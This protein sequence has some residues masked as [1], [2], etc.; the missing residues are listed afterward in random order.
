MAA[1]PLA[2]KSVFHFVT[3]K[4]RRHTVSVADICQQWVPEVGS[5]HTECSLSC[6]S[7]C[8]WN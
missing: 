6:L 1:A 4:Y 2:V 8:P 7:M 3:K 5:H